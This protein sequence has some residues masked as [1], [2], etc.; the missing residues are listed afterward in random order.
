MADEELGDRILYYGDC[1]EWIRCWPDQ[2][3]DLIYLD[4]PFNSNADDNVIFGTENDAPA[5]VRGFI[6]TWKWD[7]AAASR[8]G[9]D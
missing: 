8:G 1:F 4:P 5:Q 7:S 3:V 6:G 2:C 9:P